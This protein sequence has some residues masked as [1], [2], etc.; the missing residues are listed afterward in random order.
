MITAVVATALAVVREKERGTMESLRATPLV[1]LE[2][3]VGKTIPYLAIGSIAAA[4]TLFLAWGLFHVPMHGSLLWLALVTLLFLIGGL[5]WG[6]LISTV[7][8]TQ[9]TAFQ[10][11]MITSM[12]PSFLLSGFVFPISSMPAV[13]RWVTH[14]VPARYFLQALR[15][16]VL[17]G[18]G[19]EVWWPQ[20]VGLAV[21]ASL[22]L[23]LATARMIRQL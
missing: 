14:A 19:P 6:V 11:G 10:L 15:E 16:I 9:Q 18:V 4:G 7:A 12:L 3:L 5:A 23:L 22:V 20:A 17:K 21:Y 1:A 13:L 8:D 2:L